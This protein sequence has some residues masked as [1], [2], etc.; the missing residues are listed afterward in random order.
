M[1]DTDCLPEC[2]KE[3]GR[4]GGHGITRGETR[5]LRNNVLFPYATLVNSS[6]K[7]L[8]RSTEVG[9]RVFETSSVKS[10]YS[11]R[12]GVED[13]VAKSLRLCVLLVDL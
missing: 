9:V 5:N 12:K 3:D 1:V 8:S 13:P 11:E 10:L 2:V 4:D 6:E 7:V